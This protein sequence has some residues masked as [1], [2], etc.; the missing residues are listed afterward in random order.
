MP[1]T[2]RSKVTQRIDPIAATW[3][4]LA[5]AIGLMVGGGRDWPLRLLTAAVAFGIGG[6]LAGVRAAGRRVAHG[7]AAW[8]AAYI[9]HAAFILVAAIIDVLG[10]PAAPALMPGGGRAWLIAAGWALIWALAGAILVNRWLLPG[11]RRR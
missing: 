10:G 2:P 7:V 5:G 8:A 6:F 4:G 11:A 3:G 1:P 9:I